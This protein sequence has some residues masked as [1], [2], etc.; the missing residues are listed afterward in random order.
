[1]S[2]FYVTFEISALTE[3]GDADIQRCEA[4]ID[5]TLDALLDRSGLIDPDAGAELATG[6][7]EFMAVVEAS[8]PERA[9]STVGKLLRDCVAQVLR[10]SPGIDVEFLGATVEPNEVPAAS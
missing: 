1:M 5:A 7:V 8:T 2:R 4:F 6:R 9:V 3:R 10:G